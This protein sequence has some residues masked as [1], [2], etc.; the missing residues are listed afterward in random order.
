MSIPCL[1]PTQVSAKLILTGIDGAPR[2]Q[3][4]VWVGI[5]WSG[6]MIWKPKR[7]WF[8]GLPKK[9]PAYSLI[10]T[11]GSGRL[12][13]A[14]WSFFWWWFGHFDE[15]LCRSLIVCQTLHI[16]NIAMHFR[17]LRWTQHLARRV[18]NQV[19]RLLQVQAS[20]LR[21]LI[22]VNVDSLFGNPLW[23]TLAPG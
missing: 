18:L 23:P 4:P 21:L 22:S 9:S 7:L 14:P 3:K 16:L 20:C 11:P 2:W 15:S 19:T 17:H 13:R 8:A 10:V 12:E 1:C 6:F 5:W